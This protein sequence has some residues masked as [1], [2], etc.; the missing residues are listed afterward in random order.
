MKSLVLC[1][2]FPPTA[3]GDHRRNLLQEEEHQQE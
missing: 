1:G 2:L 3:N